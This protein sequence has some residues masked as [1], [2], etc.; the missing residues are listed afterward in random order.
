MLQLHVLGTLDLRTA[1]GVPVDSV[2]AH[3]RM[4]A[5]LVALVLARPH[6]F[7][8]RDRLCAMFWPDSDDAHAR[9]ALSQ[10]LTRLRRAI[11]A[12]AVESRGAEEV[13]VVPGT[14]ACDA[15]AFQNAVEGGDHLTAVS[16]YGGTL[17][18]GFHVRDAD[19]FEEWLEDERARLRNLA[20][21][22]SRKLMRQLVA[23]G[24]FTDAGSTAL[25]APPLEAVSEQ[26]MRELV[27]ALI[28]RGDA[29]G[30]V[31]IFEGWSARLQRELQVAPSPDFRA[32]IE[33]IRQ[34]RAPA[35]SPTPADGQQTALPPADGGMITPANAGPSPRPGTGDG[36]RSRRT[37]RGAAARL[38]VTVIGGAMVLG[39]VLLLA[40]RDS[41]PAPLPNRIAVLPF[42][43]RTG[44]PSLDPVGHMAADWVS[45]GLMQIPSLEIVPTERARQGLEMGPDARHDPAAAARE[46]G[47][48]TRAATV[49]SGAYYQQ[50]DHVWF[51]PRLT[52]TSTGRLLPA[53]EPMGTRRDLPLQ[54]VEALLHAVAGALVHQRMPPFA[55]FA[56]L[57]DQRPPSYA[58]YSAFLEGVD[59]F[60]AEAWQAS[61]QRFLDA[62]RADTTYLTPLVTA[63]TAALNLGRYATADSLLAVAAPSRQRLAPNDAFTFDFHRATLQGDRREALRLA[64]AQLARY[65]G[66]GYEYVTAVAE[67]AMNRPAAAAALLE[68]V[69]NRANNARVR[70][71][72]QT[73]ARAHHEVGD[74]RAELRAANQAAELFPGERWPLQ[75]Q[76]WALAALGRARA[77]ERHL[78][79]IERVDSAGFPLVAWYFI[80][81][82]RELDIHGHPDAAHRLQERALRWLRSSPPEDRALVSFRWAEAWTLFDLGRYQEVLEIVEPLLREQPGLMGYVAL[83]GMVAAATGDEAAV[84]EAR[85]SIR[86]LNDAN[87][88][89]GGR[90]ERLLAFLAAQQSDAGEAVRLLRE[91]WRLGDL[92][93]PE[94]HRMLGGEL[95]PIRN[96]AALRALLKPVG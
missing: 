7:Q 33:E 28:D 82:A 23:S 51:H 65:P 16:L 42:E 53:P 25:Q 22:S 14:V 2:L 11:G 5:L 6:G 48:A 34:S 89:S 61:M 85:V 29:V 32:I 55:G 10:A 3:P 26:V 68:P 24:H 35:R 8:R 64:R 40:M 57:L 75:L 59:F 45:R 69:K 1:D 17:L 31:R 19:G 90:A 94:M 71:F 79:E 20:G 41:V 18:P 27:Q 63:A 73:L 49:V 78:D 39:A 44:D 74:Y 30:A 60:V 76:A 67:L 66:S 52:D 96:D 43:N 58:A 54:G 88:Y 77:L 13:R 47:R 62:H 93:D 4:A 72:W 9:G 21:A 86:R 80:D 50:G 81:T 37:W 83:R 84:A 38:T 56:E 91:A 46:L 12:S 36:Q 87:P 95:R 92:P 70:H 15:L